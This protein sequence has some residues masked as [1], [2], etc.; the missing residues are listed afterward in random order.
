MV[1]SS[2][3][4]IDITSLLVLPVLLPAAIG[5]FTKTDKIAAF[6]KRLI[7]IALT[8]LTTALTEFVDAVSTGAVFDIGMVVL[9]FIVTYALAEGAYQGI[10]KAPLI[11]V[12][13]GSN[14]IT[15]VLDVKGWEDH[16]VA[17][18][19]A[20]LDES[21]AGY[22]AKATKADLI[23]IAKAEIPAAEITIEEVPEPKSLASIIQSHGVK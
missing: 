7:L 19:K 10:L 23:D 12:P 5:Y 6:W 9:R 8:F 22:P 4:L 3:S 14:T 1:V 16:T 2:V 21:G 18:L 17:E 20:L 13:E 15:T 11:V